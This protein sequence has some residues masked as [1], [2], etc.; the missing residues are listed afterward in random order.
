MARIPLIIAVDFDGTI[1][2]HDYPRIGEPVPGAVD[3]LRHF[4]ERGAQLILWTVRDGKELEEA[5]R[6]VQQ[7][8]IELFGINNN[9]A[10]CSE[11]PKVLCDVYVDDRALGCPLRDGPTLRKPCVD[12]VVVRARIDDMITMRRAHEDAFQRKG[13]KE[14]HGHR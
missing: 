7:R 11:S 13:R 5:V 10:F 14:A 4:H 9:P 12:W 2:E 3:A 1:V 6:Y 8:G